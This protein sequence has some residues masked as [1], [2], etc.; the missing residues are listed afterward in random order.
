MRYVGI[1][2][3]GYPWASER[4][5]DEQRE[6]CEYT[7]SYR[8]YSLVIIMLFSRKGFTCPPYNLCIKGFDE[9]YFTMDT[10]VGKKA[11]SSNART[12]NYKAC[13]R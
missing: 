9:A 3:D 1:L 11:M 13:I 7:S 4:E 12:Y 6:I 5:R 8:T 10:L 2:V